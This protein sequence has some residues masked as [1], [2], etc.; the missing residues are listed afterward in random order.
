MAAVGL[1]S[2]STTVTSTWS[3]QG[4]NRGANTVVIKDEQLDPVLLFIDL[5]IV[6]AFQVLT[7]RVVCL[8]RLCKARP[9]LPHSYEPLHPMPEDCLCQSHRIA[10]RQDHHREF[11]DVLDPQAS[12]PLRP[13][14]L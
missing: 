13:V 1:E 8:S 3:P 9:C 12:E 11:R 5:R 4:L 14:G 7:D 10:C 2:W 6:R